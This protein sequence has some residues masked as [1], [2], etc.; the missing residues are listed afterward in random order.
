MATSLGRADFLQR[1]WELVDEARDHSSSTVFALVGAWGSGKTSMLDWLRDKATG[2][3]D[4]TP[5]SVIQ[6]NPWDYPDSESL[7][8]G[9]FASLRNSFGEDKWAK[10]SKRIRDF[11][12]AV[13]PVTSVAAAF[14]MFDPSKPL[15]GA[16]KLLDN[17]GSAEAARAKLIRK[18]EAAGRPVLIVL[19]DIDR[20][21]ADELL[22]TLKLIRQ[23]GRLPYVHY[24]L[25]YDE[26]TIL[27]VLTQTNLIGESDNGRAR[28]YMEKVVQVRFDV[29]S[30][31]PADA[32]ALVNEALN[33]LGEET[34]L[35]L[36][37]DA[38]MRFTD[39]YF[40]FMA[41]RLNTPR[42]LRRYF[43]Q[44]RLLAPRFKDEV[45]FADFLSLTWI[46]TF[47]PGVYSLLQRRRAHLLGN[48]DP[49]GT[50]DPKLQQQA[51]LSTRNEW[52]RLFGDA[53]T[54]KDDRQGVHRAVASLFPKFAA[55]TEQ[56][57]K[58]GSSEPPRIAHEEYFD[59][60]F[61]AGI[62]EGDIADFTV[63][64]AVAD[65]EAGRPNSAAVEQCK[66]SLNQDPARAASKLIREAARAEV[67]S[68]A[69][70]RWLTEIYLSPKSWDS[71]L[72][73]VRQI[74]NVVSQ[75]LRHLESDEVLP[76]LVAMQQANGA[77]LLTQ[78]AHT[79]SRSETDE[80]P[81]LQLTDEH[82]AF[83]TAS[84]RAALAARKLDVT[85]VNGEER[86]VT[87]AWSEVDPEAFATWMAENALEHG[88]LRALGYFVRTTT[89]VGRAAD[90][91]IS[92][93]DT[94]EAARHFNLAEIRREY[95]DKVDAADTEVSSS[96]TRLKDTPDNRRLMA[97]ATLKREVPFHSNDGPE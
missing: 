43:A 55:A 10:A 23:L 29:P 41:P 93:F 44:V 66:R 57:R 19:D 8:L 12:V 46:R 58:S 42:A 27:D 61:S 62:P 85:N 26:A 97:L 74:E 68:P 54:R 28:D 67:T 87:W 40:Q 50:K 7:Q 5:W 69:M 92:G 59:R 49:P 73:A 60:Y 88:E 56:R 9:F 31:R 4:G 70:F 53:G 90:T 35:R 75:R 15:E 37:T 80:G 86:Y 82:R 16:A 20:I 48:Y 39:A 21:S 95:S 63:R 78:A 76:A 30:L 51:V 45:D 64:S 32:I 33:S 65:V 47:E 13:A 81:V 84:M 38:T 79:A 11:G 96:A 77:M 3:S 71:V 22:I 24:L 2:E 25:S 6:F 1:V 36:S 18:L 94:A 91:Q 83:I 14:G 89:A 52:D 34:D 72:S 17:G